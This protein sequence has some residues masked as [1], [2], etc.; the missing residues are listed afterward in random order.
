MA[1]STIANCFDCSP[2]SAVCRT[3][4]SGFD[5]INNVCVDQSSCTVANC[6]T[7]SSSTVCALCQ[8]GYS[9]NGGACAPIVCTGGQFVDPDTNT[10]TCG[11]K[12]VFVNGACVTCTDNNCLVC[13]NSACTSCVRGFY[14]SGTGCVR[15]G[16]NCEVC[17]STGCTQCRDGFILS[18]GQC[19]NPPSTKVTSVAN[20]G[21]PII[22]DT[23]CRVCDLDSATP[24]NNVCRS[25]QDGYV[26]VTGKI[27]KCSS[28]CLTC[29]STANPSTG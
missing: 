5:L 1:C 21:D 17:D 2:N 13:S 14:P 23:G 29:A 27:Y 19:K 28:T 6:R 15:C 12:S 18:S 11:S 25:A 10:C 7:C 3:C 8:N 22:C 24:P 4:R 20:N 9:L 26:L 16:S